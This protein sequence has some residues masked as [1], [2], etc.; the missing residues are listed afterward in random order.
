MIVLIFIQYILTIYFEFVYIEKIMK[1]KDNTFN[2]VFT[3]PGGGKTTLAA[4][5]VRKIMT[6]AKN[7]NKKV[8]SN[9]PIV[10]AYKLEVKDIGH[11]DLHDCDIIIDEAGSDLSNR[12]W[13][14]NLDMQ[15][16][17]VLK[18]HRHL[19]INIWLFS[20]SYGDVD[21]K[22]RELTTG[23]YMLKK[24]K[25]IPFR[26]I[27]KAIVKNVDLLNG[28]IIEYYEWD[29]PNFFK[30]WIVPNWAFFN[31]SQVDIKLPRRIWTRYRKN[32]C[33]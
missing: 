29:K 7:Q 19:N 6:N 1:K 27:A 30:F 5:L 9:V 23:L 13:Q 32:D 25:I 10:G 20:Q 26:I 3:P 24:S 17:K 12:N 16:I 8:Y 4:D 11:F 14:H 21:N 33:D 28:Q 2:Q 31:T 22:F 15:Q 18:L